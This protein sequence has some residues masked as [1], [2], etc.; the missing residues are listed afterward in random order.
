MRKQE[1][2][3]VAVYLRLS[4]INKNTEEN[5]AESNSICSQRDIIYSYLKKQENMEVYDTYIE[6]KIAG[7]IQ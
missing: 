3:H 2:Y 7:L 4:H 5:N 6:M 1:F